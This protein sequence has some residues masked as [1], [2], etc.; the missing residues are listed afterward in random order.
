MTDVN[1]REVCVYLPWPIDVFCGILTWERLR[2]CLN[3]SRS[4]SPHLHSD[5][6]KIR[7]NYQESF[8]YEWWKQKQFLNIFFTCLS[9]GSEGQ[10]QL[11]FALRQE[12]DGD[13]TAD[14][15]HLVDMLAGLADGPENLSHQPPVLLFGTKLTDR[16]HRCRPDEH[17]T[18]SSLGKSTEVNLLQRRTN[19]YFHDGMSQMQVLWE[20]GT[21]G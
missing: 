18:I 1:R 7:K 13:A 4:G 19:L 11:V 2:F 14:S 6:L 15:P 20:G 10:Q 3:N 16:K 12:R 8:C 5:T 21:G 9:E 17:K